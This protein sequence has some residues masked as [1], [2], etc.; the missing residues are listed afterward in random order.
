MKWEI[1][2]WNTRRDV[3]VF[4][5]SPRVLVHPRLVGISAFEIEIKAHTFFG[6]TMTIITFQ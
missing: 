5:N 1:N 2:C 4:L 3:N 6:M